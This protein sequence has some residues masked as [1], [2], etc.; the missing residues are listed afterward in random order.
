MT[1]DQLEFDVRCEWG[2]RGAALLAADCDAVIIVDVLSFCTCV[3]IATARGASV[4][5]HRMKDATALAYAESLGAHLSESRTAEGYSLSP[6]SLLGIPEGARLVLPSPNGAVLSLAVGSTPCFA[7]CLRNA[8]AVAEAA[9]RCGGRV[10]VLPAGERWDLDGSLR[11]AAEDL[12]GAGA[13]IA[14]LPGRR[15]PEA[16]IA[17]AAFRASEH[18]LVAALLQCGS[19][20][21]LI[22]RG[23]E[24]DVALA[25]EHDISD[26]APRLADGAYRR[27][28]D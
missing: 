1:F 28:A 23:F 5:P 13:I 25:S 18:E 21:E 19:G 20:K 10:G 16:R 14:H 11:P 8:G 17:E 3:D 27:L 15:S 4:Y 12:I 2:E 22:E 7:G 26:C 9:V 6:A 24:C